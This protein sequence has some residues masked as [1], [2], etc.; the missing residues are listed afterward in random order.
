M[1]EQTRPPVKALQENDVSQ[2]P[3]IQY[4]LAEDGVRIAFYT[5]GAGMPFVHTP[6]FP[7]GHLVAEWQYPANREYIEK[8][9]EGLQGFRYD[10]RGSGLSDRDISD[11]SQDARLRDI[12]AMVNHLG[13]RR[14]ALLGFNHSGP[15]A[16]A[17]ASRNPDR[18]SHLVLWH[19]YAKASDLTDEG[20]IEAARSL[21]QRDW[22]LYTELEGYRVSGWQG[23]QAARWYTEYI[24]ASVSPQALLSAYA[25]LADVDV[26][27]M[28]PLVQAPTLV[29]ARL[30]SHALPMNV[31]IGLTAAIPNARMVTLDGSGA[32]PFPDVTDQ[33]VGAVHSF[34]RNTPDEQSIDAPGRARPALTARE[35][36]VLRLLAN[37]QTSREIAGELSLS[38]RTVGRHITNIYA[39][40]GAAT[41]AD[42]TAYAIRHRIA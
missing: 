17:Y 24:K 35:I 4:C 19:C 21:I 2:H 22:K 33:F 13:L 20:S 41:R 25:A 27:A 37:G 26:T 39:K 15:T 10:G 40:I 28:L 36:E 16:I 30:D 11:Y 31:A 6:P 14:F 23:G 32:V 34:L 29:M 3:Q 9:T 8:L 38:V 18:V 1:T 12:D 5:R 42:A 7:L